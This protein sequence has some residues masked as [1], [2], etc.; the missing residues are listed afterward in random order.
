[1][2]KIVVVYSFWACYWPVTLEVICSYS[3]FSVLLQL[4]NNNNNNN[5]NNLFSGLFSKS[6]G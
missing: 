1:M 2:K 4:V 5:N 6:K 3:D